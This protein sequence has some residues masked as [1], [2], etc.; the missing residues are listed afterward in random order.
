M[1]DRLF[2]GAGCTLSHS[3]YL[4]QKLVFGCG[5]I[6][7][8]SSP[9]SSVAEDHSQGSLSEEFSDNQSEKKKETPPEPKVV[10]TTTDSFQGFKKAQK[11]NLPAVLIFYSPDSASADTLYEK[12]CLRTEYGKPLLGKCV[13]IKLYHPDSLS[14]FSEQKK[15]TQRLIKTYFV[16]KFPA[17]VVTRPSGKFQSLLWSGPIPENLDPR[18]PFYKGLREKLDQLIFEKHKK[19][20]Y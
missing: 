1:I 12:I 5:L 13:V 20:F 17:V 19:G 6:L 10:Y 14:D 18:K 8:L 3:R 11:S 16:G 4:L 7:W 15:R 2:A 9:F